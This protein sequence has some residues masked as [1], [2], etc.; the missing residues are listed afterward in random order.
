MTEALD[1]KDSLSTLPAGDYAGLV[2][3]L[4]TDERINLGDKVAVQKLLERVAADAGEA[5]A[6]IAALVAERN[7]LVDRL[8]AGERIATLEAEN[9]RLRRLISST[10]KNAVKHWR[11]EIVHCH[12]CDGGMFVCAD[13]GA[14]EIET[15]ER[16]CTHPPA[17]AVTGAMVEAAAEIIWNARD[18]RMG[19]PW[20][21]RPN[22][23]A[24]V[25]HT[26]EVARAA[27]QAAQEVKR[28]TTAAQA[29]PTGVFE[30]AYAEVAG[31]VPPDPHPV[32]RWP[33]SET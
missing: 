3:R 11:C 10:H 29:D 19:G 17:P 13:C 21:T 7:G 33:S 8:L 18:A 28:T 22:N 26:R 15:E 16:I 5:A 23:E 30:R 31:T 25:I 12:I 24:I 32:G 4:L 6:A 20:D 1:E 9:R 27:L 14:A 2:D